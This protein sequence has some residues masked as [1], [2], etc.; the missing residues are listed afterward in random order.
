[1]AGNHPGGSLLDGKL[2]ALL[3]RRP[4]RSGEVHETLL[5]ARLAVRFRVGTPC[6][7]GQTRV[8]E[9]QLP[10]A[11]HPPP[12]AYLAD[13]PLR[14]EPSRGVRPLVR[15]WTAATGSRQAVVEEAR[16]ATGGSVAKQ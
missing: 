13:R 6:A 11:A 14:R 15:R 1:P 16:D 8:P 9:G 12:V 3:E 2:A 7:A 10:A 5:P 4:G